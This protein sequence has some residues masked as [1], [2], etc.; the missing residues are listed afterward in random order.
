M[1]N[2]CLFYE[3]EPFESHEGFFGRVFIFQSREEFIEKMDT[4]F[5]EGNWKESPDPSKGTAIEYQTVI[6]GGFAEDTEYKWMILV[7]YTVSPLLSNI[8]IPQK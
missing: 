8:I 3:T 6:G 4:I 7:D 1:H 2:I 5:G